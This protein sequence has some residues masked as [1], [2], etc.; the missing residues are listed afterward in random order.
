MKRLR[1]NYEKYLNET[2]EKRQ[3]FDERVTQFQEKF[4]KEGPGAVGRNLDLGLKLLKVKTL[5]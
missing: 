3:S 2:I 4:I 1:G 5:I